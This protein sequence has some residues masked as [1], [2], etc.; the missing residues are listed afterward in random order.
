MDI[1]TKISD[2][3]VERGQIRIKKDIPHRGFFIERLIR[4]MYCSIFDMVDFE[5]ED[6]PYGIVEVGLKDGFNKL[7]PLYARIREFRLYNIGTRYHIDLVD[8]LNLPH[9][10][11]AMMLE[12]ARYSTLQDEKIKDDAESATRRDLKNKGFDTSKY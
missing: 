8:F 5:N 6:K 1:E 10:V 2:Y 3:L 4:E 12:E 7:N 9:H 11:T